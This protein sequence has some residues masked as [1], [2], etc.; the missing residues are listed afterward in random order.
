[1]KWIW[2]AALLLF[3]L[4]AHAQSLGLLPLALDINTWNDGG[5]ELNVFP[6]DT[7]CSANYGLL[8]IGASDNGTHDVVRQILEGG[9]SAEDLSYHDGSLA[10]GVGGE[11]DLPGIPGMRGAIAGALMEIIGQPRQV[12]LF[13]EVTDAGGANCLYTIVTWV[14]VRVLDVDLTGNPKKVIIQRD[15]E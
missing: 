8:R 11:I 15:I 5:M 10:L 7:G 9:P 14:D 4:P 13:S 2:T 3:A 12:A 1:M 6:Q